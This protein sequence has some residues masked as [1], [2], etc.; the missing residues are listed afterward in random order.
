M[1][2]FN[3][4]YLGCYQ[5]RSSWNTTITELATGKEQ[6]IANWDRAKRAWT[7]EF[8]KDIATIAEARDFFN[9]HKGKYGD[10]YFT[11]PPKN[12]NDVP[13]PI[14]AHFDSDV[15]EVAIQYNAV[16]TFTLTI[17]ESVPGGEPPADTID[18][19]NILFLGVYQFR[20]EWNT[21]TTPPT[22][23]AEQRW[24]NWDAPRYRWEIE[25]KKNLDIID[26]ARTFFDM[27]RGRYRKFL[28]NP[29]KQ[30]ADDFPEPVW[31]RFDTD[32][33]LVDVK[34]H[35]AGTFTLPII[36]VR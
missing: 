9:R 22:A 6:R 16:G 28:F 24:A 30:K 17:V 33:F 27:K 8:K 12:S 13:A 1:E 14:V 35:A 15:F 10:F 29:P 7:I 4:P 32:D 25:F 36:E 18:I 34:Y 2:T 19:F 11:P 20:V 31:V 26:Q 23:G 21:T 5:F 3:I